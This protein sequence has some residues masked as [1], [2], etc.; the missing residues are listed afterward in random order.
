MRKKTRFT[1]PEPPK[2]PIVVLDRYDTFFREKLLRAMRDDFQRFPEGLPTYHVYLTKIVED[3]AGGIVNP[4]SLS[5]KDLENFLGGMRSHVP[6]IAV[7]D[8]YIQIVRPQIRPSFFMDGY[9]DHVGGVFAEYL[10]LWR[11]RERSYERSTFTRSLAGAYRYIRQPQAEAEPADTQRFLVLKASP[12]ASFLTCYEFNAE[13]ARPH[14]DDTD[15]RL[16]TGI[17][18]PNPTAGLLLMRDYRFDERRV[19]NF[20][21]HASS[22]GEEGEGWQ[23][24]LTYFVSDWFAGSR[25]DPTQLSWE[26]GVPKHLENRNVAHVSTQEAYI[27]KLDIRTISDRIMEISDKIT[28]I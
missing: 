19:G 5:L 25:P 16:T 11:S 6:R 1:L 4:G 24:K 20:R 23:A 26:N 28:V 14:R 7:L 13:P 15:L 9:A 27:Y 10:E 12:S 18:I 2:G 8:A 17:L 21:Y 3:Y 22:P